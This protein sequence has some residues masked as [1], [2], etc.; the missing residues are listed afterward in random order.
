MYVCI[1]CAYVCMYVCMCLDDT[2]SFRYACMMRACRDM[3]AGVSTSICTGMRTRAH[4]HFS[5]CRWAQGY[6]A[7]TLWV[8]FI[9][10]ELSETNESLKSSNMAAE[11]GSGALS[12]SS[13]SSS[14]CRPAD[15]GP[16]VSPMRGMSP[17]RG[18]SPFRDPSQ[19]E[20]SPK[21]FSNAG[22][23]EQAPS[24]SAPTKYMCRFKS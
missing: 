21:R 12:F 13:R 17:T 8:L 4:T 9:E 14:K 19:T 1:V 20:D 11:H 24:P 23:R 6:L 22:S 7:F 3:D 16:S 15:D 2:A 5:C 18:L 10:Y